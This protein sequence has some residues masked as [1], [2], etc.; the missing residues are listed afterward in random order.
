MVA[1][2]KSIYLD[3][4]DKE[5]EGSELLLDVTVSATEFSH[6]NALAKKQGIKTEGQGVAQGLL[7]KVFRAIGLSEDHCIPPNADP[8][9]ILLL[10]SIVIEENGPLF[11]LTSGR[12]SDPPTCIRMATRWSTPNRRQDHR[13]EI[14]P[15]SRFPTAGPNCC[16]PMCVPGD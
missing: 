5:K 9:K 6:S 7:D 1:H 8:D 10:K 16:D 11:G 3:I 15:E 4:V 12:V 2:V 13:V 14:A